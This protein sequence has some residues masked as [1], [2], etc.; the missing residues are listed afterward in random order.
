MTPAPE[1]RW[2]L[3]GELKLETK[4]GLASIRFTE[5]EASVHVDT[6]FVP[7]AARRGGL[8]A[9]LLGRVLAYA[10]RLGKEV[11]LSARPLGVSGPEVLPKL[12]AWYETFGFRVVTRDSG[13]AE[14]T[15]P[16][17]DA[18]AAGTG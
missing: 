6:V 18:A 7:A 8:G 1:V 16:V 5:D 4:A 3:K 13:K 2:P 9:M 11:R 10:D 14:M 15:R 17:P 12:V